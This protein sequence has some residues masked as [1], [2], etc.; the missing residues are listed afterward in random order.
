MH[1][2]LSVAEAALTGI[3]HSRYSFPVLPRETREAQCSFQFT[4][5]SDKLPQRK[6]PR[7][8]RELLRRSRLCTGPVRRR[9]LV[10]DGNARAGASRCS[11]RLD[12]LRTY[13][14]GVFLTMVRMP[15]I[16]QRHDLL[17][18]QLCEATSESR[19][20][21]VFGSREHSIRPSAV[22]DDLAL[23]REASPNIEGLDLGGRIEGRGLLPRRASK[24]TKSESEYNY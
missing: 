22:K 3:R 5:L 17:E 9:V 19:G 13:R 7:L 21:G 20:P 16:Y 15:F 18:T 10:S 1:V 6:S 2:N 23:V 12:Y 24:S 4:D 14:L 8:L 11:N